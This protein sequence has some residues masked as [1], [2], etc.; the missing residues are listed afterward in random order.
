MSAPPL[1]VTDFA[2]T[3]L[4]AASDHPLTPAVRWSV[5]VVG[6]ALTGFAV[7]LVATGSDRDQVSRAVLE[8][9]VVGVPIAVGLWATRSP[10]H[11]RFGAML[12]GAGAIWSLTA[13]AESSESVPYSIGRVAAWLIF[14]VLV[15]LMLVYPEGGCG[16][17]STGASTAASS[18]S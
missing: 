11:V 8:A 13:L 18:R 3:P 15:Y 5:G 4:R 1:T 16:L 6:A 9:L 14:P 7:A 2:V 12:I 17:A 10:R